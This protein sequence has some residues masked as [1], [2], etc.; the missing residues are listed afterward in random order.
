LLLLAPSAVGDAAVPA[1]A[2]AEAV[3]RPGLLQPSWEPTR[4]GLTLAEPDWIAL[5]LGSPGLPLPA[6]SPGE[7]NASV[8]LAG[9]APP[10]AGP[11]APVAEPPAALLLL[12]AGSLLGAAPPR[13]SG[14]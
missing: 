4:Q 9:L 11:S 2:F 5:A 1:P 14:P 8:D 3:P 13:R 6:K 12:L 7:A 10:L